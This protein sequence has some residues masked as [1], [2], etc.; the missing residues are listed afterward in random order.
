V[1]PSLPLTGTTELLTRLDPYIPDDFI[2]ARWNVRPVRGPHRSF[3]AAQLWRVHLL[4]LLTP[5]HSLNLLLTMLAEQRSWRRFARL[6]HRDRIPDARMMNEFRGRVGVSG[7]RAIND[8]L[9]QPLI[10]Q[11]AGWEQPVALIDATDLEA[12]C[13]GFKKRNSNL[14]STTGRARWT[15]TQDRPEP[16]VCRLQKAHVAT[17]VAFSHRQR[18]ACAIG[19]LGHSGQCFRGWIAGAK[20]SLLCAT[21]VVVAQDRRR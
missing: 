16:L 12:A 19:E 2:N 4:S 9:R 5:V 21:V 14:H 15:H 10:E 3:S 20:S 18:V 8:T 17:V 6:T 11:A 7:F 13:S 1:N